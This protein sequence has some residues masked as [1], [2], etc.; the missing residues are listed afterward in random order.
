MA[1]A[2][3]LV[4]PKQEHMGQPNTCAL[5]ATGVLITSI[6]H[7]SHGAGGEFF[8][9]SSSDWQRVFGSAVSGSHAVQQWRD[10]VQIWSGTVVVWDNKNGVHGRRDS[11]K[12]AGQWCVNDTVHPAASTCNQTPPKQESMNQAEVRTDENL[13]QQVSHGNYA[14]PPF[15]HDD[16]SLCKGDHGFFWKYYDGS[17][18]RSSEFFETLSRDPSDIMFPITKW[19]GRDIMFPIWSRGPCIPCGWWGGEYLRKM[20]PRP[21][22]ART[23]EKEPDP[24]FVTLVWCLL[25][26][27]VYTVC[28]YGYAL[29]GDLLV[30]VQRNA[31]ERKIHEFHR[32]HGDPSAAGL[33]YAHPLVLGDRK[34][35]V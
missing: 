11:G 20:L 2:E 35:V 26:P 1:T 12:A 34:S 8:F 31:I 13:A 21:S 16:Q 15:P 17:D 24:G 32:A 23:K 4:S 7:P 10:G 22:P 5:E 30:T 19:E 14:Q 18:L 27:P 6:N 9:F 29:C 28:W 25:G 3:M 33:P